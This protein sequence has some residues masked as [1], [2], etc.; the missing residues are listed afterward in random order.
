MRNVDC[1]LVAR[2]IG[3]EAIT[4]RGR[5][6]RSVISAIHR[7]LL[8]LSWGDHATPLW[9]ETRK[10]AGT[11]PGQPLKYPAGMVNFSSIQ[12]C[13][14]LLA[15]GARPR[16][17]WRQCVGRC[18]AQYRI[19]VGVSRQTSQSGLTGLLIP[20]APPSREATQAWT[21]RGATSRPSRSNSG[22]LPPGS[23]RPRSNIRRCG[24][25]GRNAAAISACS[26]FTGSF[27]CFAFGWDVVPKDAIRKG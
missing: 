26:S 23:D 25:V 7:G 18:L 2:A 19:S 6:E 20:G 11:D 3:G 9:Q 24:S 17:P 15:N 21:V 4:V 22:S 13:R 10:T 14:A 16:R 1:G 12:S 27:R 5:F 8:G